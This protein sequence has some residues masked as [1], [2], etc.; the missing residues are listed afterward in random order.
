[1]EDGIQCLNP[2]GS[3]VKRPKNDILAFKDS[4]SVHL[5]EIIVVCTLWYGHLSRGNNNKTWRT[6]VEIS[7]KKQLKDEQHSSSEAKHIL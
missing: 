3:T 4:S 1:M 2:S 5:Y 7:N 6:H